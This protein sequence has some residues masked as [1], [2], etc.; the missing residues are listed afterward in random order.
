MAVIY[1][2]LHENIQEAFNAA[3]VEIMS[4]HYAALRDGNQTTIPSNHL[5][6][7]YRAPS[8]RVNGGA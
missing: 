8:F 1:S 4:P 3:G 2:R 6:P 5:A 7:D